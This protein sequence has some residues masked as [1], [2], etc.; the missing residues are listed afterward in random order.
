[1]DFPPQLIELDDDLALRRFEGEADLPEFFR[2]IEESLEHLRP[3]MPWVA[4]HSLARTAEFLTSRWQRW[5][6]GAEFTYAV[7]LDGAVVGLGALVR[8]DDTSDGA[9][10]IGYWLHPA[11]TGRGV[12]TRA[13]RALAEQAFR[14]PGTAYVEI[15]HDRANLA[16]AA[17]PAR[18]GF[19][20]HARRPAERLAPGETGEVQ[21]WRL[22]R[23]PLPVAR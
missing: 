3:W 6:D 18:L 5:E 19:T 10:E 1:M 21:V 11:A 22:T 8:F 14:L 7:V 2:V 15:V 16:S 4:E 17:V 23:P 9:W 20:E 13:A 12:A